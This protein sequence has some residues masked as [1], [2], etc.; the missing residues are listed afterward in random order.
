MKRTLLA[1]FGLVLLAGCFNET[2]EESIIRENG[3]LTGHSVEQVAKHHRDVQYATADGEALTLDV[4]APDGDGPFPALMII[5][6]GGWEMHT[7]TVMEGMAR[8]VTNRGYVVFNINYR[9]RP[10]VPMESIVGD[11]LGALLWIKDHGAEYGADVERLAV[12]G[13]SAGGHLTAMI[14]TMAGDPA[15][16]PTYQGTG[17]PDYSIAAACPSYGVFDMRMVEAVPGYAKRTMGEK[18]K[19][20]PERYQLLSPIFHVRAGLPPQ[21]VI[22]GDRDPL[23]V[24]SKDY[25]EALEKAGSP[26]EFWVH[27]GQPHAF[28]NEFWNENGTKGYD[29]IVEFLDKTLK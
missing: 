7:N 11:C 1:L 14:V 23:Y 12:T 27:K 25:V 13:D 26:V 17:E 9:V 19:K 2:R 4:S 21:L 29:R 22:V 24:Q 16:T 20:D 8:Y 15:F 6:G 10:D 3:Y 5:H 18:S 28:L